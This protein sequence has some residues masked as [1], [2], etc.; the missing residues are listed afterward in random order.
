VHVGANRRREGGREGGQA[1]TVL[2]ELQN[3]VQVVLSPN[4]IHVLND[5][6]EGGKEGGREGGRACLPFS[7]NSR[8]ICRWCWVRIASTYLTILG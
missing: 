6:W 1:R 4:G 8:M 3:H 5:V 7:M 2:H